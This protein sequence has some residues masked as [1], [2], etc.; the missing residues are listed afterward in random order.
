[1]DVINSKGR[2]LLTGLALALAGISPMAFGADAAVCTACH[3][4]QASAFDQTPH[5]KALPADTSCTSCH[6]DGQD[7]LRAPGA[8]G[9]ILSFSDESADARRAACASCHED[10]HSGGLDAHTQAGLACNDCHKIHGTSTDGVELGQAASFDRGLNRGLDNASQ[11][12]FG[13]HEDTFTQFRF[14]EGHRLHQGAV[15]CTSCHDPHATKVGVRL[16]GFD[17]M[18]SGCHADKDGPFVFEH[19]A[20]RVEGCIACHAPHGSPNRHMLTHQDTGELCYTCHGVVA[21]F[22][23]GFSSVGAPRFNEKTVCTN[24]H[25][26]IHGSNLDRLFLR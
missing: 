2:A 24:C 7:H 13:C 6:G 14:N 9:S 10:A 19:G 11:T 20:Q 16:G 26:T 25:A 12:C 21:Q 4:D 18:C 8:Q 3:A 1:M 17:D 23:L 22:H 5:G 15:A